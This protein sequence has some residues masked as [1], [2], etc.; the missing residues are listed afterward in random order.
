MFRD[1]MEEVVYI[2]LDQYQKQSQIS[3][4]YDIEW[5]EDGIKF[6]DKT[7]GIESFYP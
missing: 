4:K 6:S 3:S 7:K 2:E 1:N 5:C